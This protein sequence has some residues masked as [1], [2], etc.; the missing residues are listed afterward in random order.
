MLQGAGRAGDFCSAGCDA[1]LR[2][3]QKRIAT[4]NEQVQP[5]RVYYMTRLC[6]E[7]AAWIL[8][9]TRVSI[10]MFESAYTFSRGFCMVL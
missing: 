2:R 8:P 6:Y 3:S 1:M 5:L 10:L 9:M 7:A 4:T